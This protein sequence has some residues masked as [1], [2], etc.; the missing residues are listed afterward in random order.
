MCVRAGSVAHPGN[1]AHWSAFRILAAWP[2]PPKPLTPNVGVTAA[3]NLFIWTLAN[4]DRAVCRS[5]RGEGSPSAFCCGRDGD[6]ADRVFAFDDLMLSAL[7]KQQSRRLVSCKRDFI[8]IKDNDGRNLE[9]RR[10]RGYKVSPVEL[11]RTVFDDFIRASFIKQD[12]PEGVDGST[13]YR[14]T[15]D[16][17]ERGRM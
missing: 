1:Y 7:L 11:P 6:Y 2:H 5:P 15:N 13:T 9:F 16:G 3:T 17:R 14:L 10:P 4:E 12:G 8:S